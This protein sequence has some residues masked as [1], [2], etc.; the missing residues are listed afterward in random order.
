MIVGLIQFNNS[1]MLFSKNYSI[2]LIVKQS[3]RK[4]GAFNLTLV[5][6]IL[7]YLRNVSQVNKKNCTFIYKR[8]SMCVNQLL[9]PCPTAYHPMDCSQT[10]LFMGVSRQEYW[11]GLPCPPPGWFSQPRD[12]T[13]HL[14]CLLHCRWILFPWSHLGSPKDIAYTY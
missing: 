1:L 13:Q 9:Q 5:T 10:P 3:V 7:H 6:K 12:W 14:L 11:S 8:Y 2:I 4:W